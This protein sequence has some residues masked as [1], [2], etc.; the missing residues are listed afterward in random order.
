MPKRNCDSDSRTVRSPESVVR[1]QC[2]LMVCGLP[3]TNYTPRSGGTSKRHTCFI[4]ILSF[5]CV[6]ISGCASPAYTIRQHPSPNESA[7][8]VHIER[9]I[10][11]YQAQQLEQQ[12]V[13]SIGAEERLNGFAVQQ[14][15][16]RLS[17]VTERPLLRYHALLLRD[18]DPNAV[19]LADGRIYL[20]TGL[21]TYLASRGSRADELAFVLAHE[22]AHTVAQHLVKR[23][24]MLQQQQLLMALIATGASAMTHNAT[25]GVQQ[26]GRL[27][28]DIASLTSEIRNSGY[29]QEQELEADQ[30]GMHYV[31]RAGFN[32]KAALDLLQDFERFE[33]PGALLRTHPYI[34]LRRAYLGRYLAETGALTK[35][36]PGI[37]HAG[38]SRRVSGRSPSAQIGITLE[39]RRQQLK[40]VQRGYPV[41]SISW[42]N[43]Q[44]QIDA[45]EHQP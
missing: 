17:R 14:I 16:D 5:G 33:H 10:S 30:L 39:Q 18:Q 7:A 42:S 25:E 44:R 32:P 43:L 22:I 29:S 3:T 20:T 26:A 28:L 37:G 24:Q 35:P 38:F 36:S 12:G 8:A 41:G 45:L 27:A 9:S 1:G 31:I 13:Q 4:H 21:L 15:V 11:T 40:E 34:A 19:A 23:Y 6:A 2:P